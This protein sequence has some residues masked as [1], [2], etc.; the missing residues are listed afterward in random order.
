MHVKRRNNILK[1]TKGFRHGRKKLIKQAQ[2]AILKA[3]NYA[4]RDRRAK[5]RTARRLWNVKIGIALKP[6]EI[7]YSRF[8]DALKKNKIEIDRKVL[9][10][11]AENNKEIFAKIV[12]KVKKV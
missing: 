10:D 11:L 4:F 7:S 1:Q 12:A 5:K 2:P 9:A 6:F 8:I 3:G